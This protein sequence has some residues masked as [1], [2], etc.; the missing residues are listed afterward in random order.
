MTTGRGWRRPLGLAP[1]AVLSSHA[2]AD[3]QYAAMQEIGPIPL[4]RK[5][6]LP[7]K[8]TPTMRRATAI[9]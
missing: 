1:A 8:S 2:L 9:L 7:L 3:L 6:P 4:R 5:K